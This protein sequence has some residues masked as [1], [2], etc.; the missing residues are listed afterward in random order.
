MATSTTAVGGDDGSL[1][2]LAPL[3]LDSGGAVG[4]CIQLFFTAE[5]DYRILLL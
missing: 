2:V 1:V 5:S 4:G 3:E